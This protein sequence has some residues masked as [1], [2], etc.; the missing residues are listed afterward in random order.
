MRDAKEIWCANYE[1]AVH[2]IMFEEDCDFEQAER[3]LHECLQRDPGYINDYTFDWKD[4][5][6]L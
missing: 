2:D 5:Y 1:R 6:A 3:K 4:L